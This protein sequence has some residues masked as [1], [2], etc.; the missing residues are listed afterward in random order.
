MDAYDEYFSKEEQRLL[1]EYGC[2]TIQEV[3]AV[4][5]AKLQN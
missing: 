3:I 2:A 5:E 1:K 4:L